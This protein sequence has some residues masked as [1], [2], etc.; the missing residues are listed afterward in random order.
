MKKKP[1]NGPHGNVAADE[2]K[3]SRLQ[4]TDQEMI[5]AGA[6]RVWCGAGDS[7]LWRG[8]GN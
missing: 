8:G 3:L 7:L 5:L 1:S 4:S 6:R 2:Y